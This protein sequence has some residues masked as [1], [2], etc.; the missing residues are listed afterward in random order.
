MCKIHAMQMWHTIWGGLI[1]DARKE[2]GLSREE[3][4]E[5]VHVSVATVSRWESGELGVRD[6]HKLA[7]AEVLDKNVRQ[8]F[9]LERGGGK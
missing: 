6:S 9:P 5:A 7:I 1:K 4:A 8:L 2:R 3:F